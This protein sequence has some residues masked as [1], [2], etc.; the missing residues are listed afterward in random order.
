MSNPRGFASLSPEHRREIA[1]KGGKALRPDQRSFYK[2][3]KLAA[4]AGRLGGQAKPSAK[5]NDAP[6]APRPASVRASEAA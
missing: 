5:D 1:S 4:D 2:D 6:R 3:R